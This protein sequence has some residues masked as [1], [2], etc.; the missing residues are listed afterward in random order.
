MAL[1]IRRGISLNLRDEK[2]T[3]KGNSEIP[4]QNKF[5]GIQVD[6]S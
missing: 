1:A 3:L 5:I 6:M 4:V 2:E